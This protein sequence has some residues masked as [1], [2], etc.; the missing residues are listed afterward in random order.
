VSRKGKRERG[1]ALSLKGK[2]RDSIGG[3][4]QKRIF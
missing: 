4:W 1:K 2:T 3:G